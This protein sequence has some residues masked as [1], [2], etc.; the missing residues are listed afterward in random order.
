M[1]SDEGSWPWDGVYGGWRSAESGG[2]HG[3][4]YRILACTCPRTGAGAQ[5]KTAKDSRRLYLRGTEV[6]PTVNLDPLQ[7]DRDAVAVMDVD[8]KGVN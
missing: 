8:V 4:C 5:P 2:C 7:T 1:N 3:L 6:T